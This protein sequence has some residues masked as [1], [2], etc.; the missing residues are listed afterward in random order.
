MRVRYIL[1]THRNEDYVSGSIELASVS[2]A[3]IWHADGQWDYRYGTPVSDEQ[4]WRVGRLKIKA[5]L[6]PGH[7]PGMM[8]YLLHDDD[9]APW[10]LFSGDALFSGDVGRVDFMGI[11]RLDEMAALLYGTLF[12][13]FLPYGD[14][15]IVCPAHGPGSVCASA[16]SDRV[17]TTIGLEP[18]P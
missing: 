14:G 5:L 8:S 18:M 2:G 6:S 12:E 9:D 15:I 11:D 1:E 4:E 16:I 7:T 10:V 3:E 17:W 13:R